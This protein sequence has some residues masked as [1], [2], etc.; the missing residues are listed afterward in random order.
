[1]FDWIFFQHVSDSV[2]IRYTKGQLN[3]R[4]RTILES[5]LLLCPICQMQLGDLDTDASFQDSAA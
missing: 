2:L 3:S 4:E 5:H 1:M